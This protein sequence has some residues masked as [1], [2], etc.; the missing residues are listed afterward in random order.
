LLAGIEGLRNAQ[1]PFACPPGS[2]HLRYAIERLTALYKNDP[3]K[4]REWESK[5][6]REYA[7]VP[8]KK[9]EFVPMT[10]EDVM[11]GIEKRV[12]EREGK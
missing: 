2:N 4:R 1:G 10:F 12:K 3:E 5:L 7:P 6:P 8:R 9:I 11:A